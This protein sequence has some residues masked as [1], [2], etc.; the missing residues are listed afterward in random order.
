MQED[1]LESL[2]LCL[3]SVFSPFVCL[4]V[5]LSLILVSLHSCSSDLSVSFVFL[6]TSTSSYCWRDLVDPSGA[7][8]Q[9]IQKPEL[10]SD[11]TVFCARLCHIEYLKMIIEIIYE[12][13]DDSR[14]STTRFCFL[15]FCF[16][17]FGLQGPLMLEVVQKIDLQKTLGRQQLWITFQKQTRPC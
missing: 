10:R 12:I 2:T 13:R 8:H 4:A 17:V 6:I 11:M 9:C 1:W 7:C 14:L 5:R 15:F 16:F 3:Y